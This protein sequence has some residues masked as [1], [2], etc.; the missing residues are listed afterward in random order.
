MERSKTK[1]KIKLSKTNI[2]EYEYHA[3][4]NEEDSTDSTILREN[5]VKNPHLIDWF[6]TIRVLLSVGYTWGRIYTEDIQ[7]LITAAVPLTANNEI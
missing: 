5:I 4:F 7:R 2:N 6:F 1:Y 3:L